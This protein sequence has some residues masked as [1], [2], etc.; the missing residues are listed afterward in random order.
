MPFSP[1]IARALTTVLGD[2]GIRDRA[3]RLHYA[4][5]GHG[6]DAFGLNPEFV[7]LGEVIGKLAYEKYFRVQSYGAENI[8]STGPG[9]LAANHSGTLPM[10]G[11]MLWVDVIRH[12]NPPRCSRAPTACCLWTT[13]WPPCSRP[14]RCGASSS[15]ACA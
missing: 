4:N 6:Y 1:R 5:A 8:P 13:P 14:P 3:E 15:K 2:S 12:T 7:G 11:A 9:I 10:D